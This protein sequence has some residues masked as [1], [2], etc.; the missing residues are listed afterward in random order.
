MQTTVMTYSNF[1]YDDIY[2]IDTDET[3][4]INW[5]S[6]VK[7]NQSVS[8]QIIIRASFNALYKDG[9]TYLLFFDMYKK[10]SN[11]FNRKT[12]LALV[13]IDEKGVQRK[14]FYPLEAETKMWYS[15]RYPTRTPDNTFYLYG[16]KGLGTGG[17]ASVQIK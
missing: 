9:K 6:I 5:T 15:L 10:S 16:L 17:Y 2:V 1:I 3:G 13:E 12:P 14:E 4:K 7:K 8:D 11:P